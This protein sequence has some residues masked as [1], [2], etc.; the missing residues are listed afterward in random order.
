M[1]SSQSPIPSLPA[2]SE[3]LEVDMAKDSSNKAPSQDQEALLADNLN[4]ASGVREVSQNQS[5]FHRLA[6]TREPASA[7]RLSRTSSFGENESHFLEIGD[8]QSENDD[9]DNFI[10]T[11][12]R[13][14]LRQ[15]IL[16][17]WCGFRARAQSFE[18]IAS[19]HDGRENLPNNV[20]LNSLQL[21]CGKRLTCGLCE[22]IECVVIF[23]LLL[24]VTT[25]ALVIRQNVCWTSEDELQLYL[26]LERENGPL[27]LFGTGGV[28]P[29][30]PLMHAHSHND[31]QQ[32]VPVRLALAAGFCSIEADVFLRDNMLLTG[33][34]QPS[35]NDLKDQYL[36]PL[37]QLAKRD[38][39]R[40]GPIN[41]LSERLGL[42]TQQTLMIDMKSSS[43]DTWATLETILDEMNTEAGFQVFECYDNQGE[44]L[45]EP[46][47]RR[48]GLSP[49]Q[50]VMS[51]IA[52]SE[53]PI[54]ANKLLSKGK[55]CTRIDG[56]YDA[57]SPAPTDPSVIR[58]LGMM[59]ASW[60]A[61]YAG[62]LTEAVEQIHAVAPRAKIRFW[63]TPENTVTWRLLLDA[64]V[65]LIST[66]RISGLKA[67]LLGE[68]M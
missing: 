43:Y 28:S 23:S 27:D 48:T 7:N 60:H 68:T 37:I 38:E 11:S 25:M 50:V 8:N 64:G 2:P 18:P 57:S 55:H 24:L 12:R 40:P 1:P 4:H 44:P 9:E 66:D 30:V 56:R 47:V 53:I 62:N 15:R 29:P 31:Y 59:S 54:L 45:K 14:S 3:T 51:G 19:S 41:P 46:Q 21:Q 67:F 13:G 26:D 33:H 52:P 35:D 39:A 61:S 10:A 63:D 17:R 49:V 22:C 32:S 34:V 58:T 20:Q 36:R 65:D 6:E 42:C 5:A 16:A